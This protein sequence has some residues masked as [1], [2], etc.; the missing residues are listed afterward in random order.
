MFHKMNLASPAEISTMTNRDSDGH[1]DRYLTD[2]VLLT[3][4]P[5]KKGMNRD[6][7]LLPS[8]RNKFKC[9]PYVEVQMSIP[10]SSCRALDLGC[11]QNS[12][13]DKHK[14]KYTIINKI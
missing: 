6:I 2:N 1:H 5:M 9:I 11:F 13:L 4:T 7:N 8:Q 14:H 12:Q 10:R 3:V